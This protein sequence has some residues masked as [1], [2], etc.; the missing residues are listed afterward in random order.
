LLDLLTIALCGVLCGAES[1]VDVE[2]FGNA[3]VAWF[4]DFL[5]LPNGIPSHDTFGRVFARLNPAQFQ[6]CF[7][8][9]VRDVVAATDGQ[10]TD[11]QVVA[12]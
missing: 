5:A 8:A 10:V 11:G 12:I 1:W 3:K 7:L 2:Q 9:W 6:A 4:R